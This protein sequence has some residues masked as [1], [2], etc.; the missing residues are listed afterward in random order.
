MSTPAPVSSIAR[1]P[2]GAVRINGQLLP[3]WIY[4]RVSNTSFYESD[5]FE[6]KYAA[7]ALPPGYDATWF[8]SQTSDIFVEILGGSPTI[9]DVNQ[10][11]SFVYGRV[12][13]IEYDPV[14]ECLT[15][16]G[17]DLVGA[18]IDQK[19]M[20]NYTN[21]R[22]SDIVQTLATAQNVSYQITPTTNYTGSPVGT[23]TVRMHVGSA[24]D[25][26]CDL[27]REAGFIVS[28]KNQTLYFGPDNTGTGTTLA[29]SYQRAPTGGGTPIGNF[30]SIHFTRSLTV[31]KGIT[32]TVMSAGTTGATIKKSYPT[33]PRSIAPGK[34]SPYGS[35]TNYYVT[36]PAGAPAG[37]VLQRAETLYNQIISHAM[38]LSLRM[39]ADE[40]TTPFSS[41][42]V[43]GTGTSAD[44]VYFPRVVTRIMSVDDGF[45]MEIDAQSNSPNLTVAEDAA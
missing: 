36:M 13:D 8:M 4:W 22:A 28:M 39:P 1:T 5:V 3:G 25:L 24:W 6:V 37:K 32:V 41:I 16:T 23:D 35:T 19:I 2:R 14:S 17:R 26:L 33:A 34:S 44:Q 42:K 31:V 11:T 18:F 43:T 9:P 38:R 20:A 29:I 27:A 30:E 21:Q 15:L 40:T 10:L 45:S 7:S 12:D